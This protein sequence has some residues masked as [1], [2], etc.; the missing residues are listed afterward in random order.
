MYKFISK[1]SQNASY[2][3]SLC[4]DSA[5]TRTG[6]LLFIIRSC[7]VCRRGGCERGSGEGGERQAG[8]TH[9]SLVEGYELTAVHQTQIDLD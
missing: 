4:A 1:H 2:N 8:Q 5:G 3:S 6:E 7:R 9:N